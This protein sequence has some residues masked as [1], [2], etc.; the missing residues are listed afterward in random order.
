VDQL[1]EVTTDHHSAQALPPFAASAVASRLLAALAS[2]AVDPA[3]SAEAAYK[4][5]RDSISKALLLPVA[6]ASSAADCPEVVALEAS[7]AEVVV[8]AEA[9]AVRLVGRERREDP[10]GVLAVVMRRGWG[11]VDRVVRWPSVGCWDW[12]VLLWNVHVCDAWRFSLSI[13]DISSHQRKGRRGGMI[14]WVFDVLEQDEEKKKL[15]GA[16]VLCYLVSGTSDQAIYFA[17]STT[18]P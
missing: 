9:E 7:L 12:D 5:A 15:I 6:E 17:Q 16:L 11:V 13:G 1:L 2:H 4:V 8:A 18:H 10:M 14:D 3:E